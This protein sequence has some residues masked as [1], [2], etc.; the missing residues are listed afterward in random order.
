MESNKDDLDNFNGKTTIIHIS[1]FHFCKKNDYETEIIIE[2]LIKDVSNL[3]EKYALNP[4]MLIL[5]GDIAHS[6]KEE[7]YKIALKHINNLIKELGIPIKKVF[8]VP[9]NHDVNRDDLR[10]SKLDI[11]N[12]AKVNEFLQKE[13]ERKE[14]FK[15]L[16][17]FYGFVRNFYSD[18]DYYQN[19]YYFTSK[20]KTAY[21]N[22]GIV[23]LNSSWYSG[24]TKYEKDI[25][26]DDKKLLVGEHQIRSAYK[27][28][29]DSDVIITIMHHPLSQLKD[30]DESIV[31]SYVME[32]SDFL[33][34]GHDHSNSSMKLVD[35][36]GK[37]HIITAG[38]CYTEKKDKR[39]VL[40]ELD[41]SNLEYTLYLRR[42]SD[43][44]KNWGADTLTYKNSD[45]IYNHRIT[46]DKPKKEHNQVK[47]YPFKETTAVNYKFIETYWKDIIINEKNTKKD[48]LGMR[49]EY[50]KKSDYNPDLPEIAI[51]LLK[52]LLDNQI[53]KDVDELQEILNIQFIADNIHKIKE[54]IIEYYDYDYFDRNKESIFSNKEEIKKLVE[55]EFYSKKEKEIAS[56]IEK[57]LKQEYVEKE[58][59]L[60]SQYE[61][62][63]STIDRFLE[64]SELE[65]PKIKESEIIHR[66]IWYEELNLRDDPFPSFIALEG[67]DENL[68]E[69]IIVKTQIFHDFDQL[70][71]DLPDSMK[72]RS[73]LV[74]GEMGSGKTTLF[75]YL[76]NSIHMRYSNIFVV[77]IFLE[78]QSD[79]ENIRNDF[80]QLLFEHLSEKYFILTNSSTGYEDR[81]L[82]DRIILNLFKSIMK[83]S[84]I[85]NFIIVIDDLHKH[86]KH[87]NSVFDFV[88]G[89]QIFRSNMYEN[90]INLT[91]LMAGDNNWINSTEGLRKIGGSIDV[92]KR[93][94]GINKNE[95]IELINKRLKAFARDQSNPPVIDPNYVDTV[96]K[97]LK[98]RYA[99]EITFRDFLEEIKKHLEGYEFESLKLSIIRDFNTLSRMRLDIS[100]DHPEIYSKLD[101]IWN[102]NCDKKESTFNEFI[103]ILQNMY[104][105][106]IINNSIEYRTNETYLGYLL[107][108]NLISKQRR[109]D[110][111]IF[112][113]N[114]DLRNMFR[115]FTGKYGFMPMEYLSKIYL[116]DHDNFDIKNEEISKLDILIK[117][118]GGYGEEFLKYLNDACELHKQILKYTTSLEK[119]YNKKDF[120]EK[121]KS[122]I[123][124]IMRTIY[125]SC[126]NNKLPQT[127]SIYDFNEIFIDNWY[128]NQYLSEFIDIIQKKEEIDFLSDTDITEISQNYFRSFKSM[129]SELKRYLQ[130]NSIFNLY[131]KFIY[132]NDKKSLN[133]I[134]R[135]FYNEHYQSAI[136]KTNKLLKEK[137]VNIIYSL[138]CL[139]FGTDKWKRGLPLDIKGIISNSTGRESKE[140]SILD[141]LSIN[142][143]LHTC[144]NLD[145]YSKMALDALFKNLD[146]EEYFAYLQKNSDK[147]FNQFK[148]PDEVLEYIIK[149]KDLINSIDSFY[150]LLFDNKIPFSLNYAN[151]GITASG[152]DKIMYK[153]D[154]EEEVIS[155]IKG[156][157]DI[158]GT[159]SLNFN[160]YIPNGSFQSLSFVDWVMYIYYMKYSLEL[161]SINVTPCGWIS[162]KLK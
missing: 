49:K 38:A 17:N 61:K 26:D 47:V 12:E 97:I 19:K 73:Y 34:H 101:H 127:N 129:V 115:K 48:I 134:R 113:L 83:Y 59:K 67:I 28:V 10:L 71:N 87:L 32:K 29:D 63:E 149:V 111:F 62:F 138:N 107:R 143:L 120:L 75:K 20:I 98:N 41:F 110:S 157:L 104:E 132:V 57:P 91:I 156:K 39:Y 130:Y 88:S 8:I 23:C 7:D 89:L 152:K 108:A 135:N 85:T 137:L 22:L 65:L 151:L 77:H 90:N 125:L 16:D 78:A 103:H 109:G 128:D 54:K 2:N 159:I 60:I 133:E 122:S 56:K 64:S 46:K 11:S 93:I 44:K 123:I 102:F 31:H 80:Y 136:E 124:S 140:V 106:G 99:G 119:E 5:S 139:I 81:Y 162:I 118:G 105:K 116:I 148:L 51:T 141:I 50:Y 15:K 155:K 42:F 131:S 35:P 160:R 33:F 1:D 13:D 52:Y 45:G 25:F 18:Y 53:I 76:Q 147:K 161:I 82:N 6:G 153:Y 100:T 36:D 30:F 43:E 117:T 69:E 158:E 112:I 150:N 84:N 72:R 126:E 66:D 145:T 9:G 40:C 74:Y 27:D 68:Y 114:K 121:C 55:R 37:C 70:V 92:R 86:R 95:A 94:P 79:F 21:C 4:N 3:R 142:D 146:S 58:R 144:L 96:F 14:V 24:E 154:I